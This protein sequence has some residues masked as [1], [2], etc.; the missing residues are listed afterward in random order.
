MKKLMYSLAAQLSPIVDGRIYPMRL[1]AATSE[2]PNTLPA[3]VYQRISSGHI[4][5]HDRQSF[6]IARVQIDAYADSYKSAQETADAI[7][8][9]LCGYRGAMGD[10]EVGYILRDNA[11]DEY[12]PDVKMHRVIIDYRMQWKDL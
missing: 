7:D 11:R 9:V 4:I 10:V 2:S 3:I 8:A 1:D 5:T 12:L 6:E